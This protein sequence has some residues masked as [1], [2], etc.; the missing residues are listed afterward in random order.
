MAWTGVL[1]ETAGLN[2][3]CLFPVAA[4][5]YHSFLMFAGINCTDTGVPASGSPCFNFYVNATVI[6][7]FQ[8]SAYK[9]GRLYFFY[10][11]S[12]HSYPSLCHRTISVIC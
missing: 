8:V 4:G 5:S 11:A 9:M 3:F 1:K 10:N 7:L 2:R 12:R 6:Q